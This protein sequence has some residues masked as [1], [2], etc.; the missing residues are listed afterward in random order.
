MTSI[1]VLQHIVTKETDRLEAH[2]RPSRNSGWEYRIFDKQTQKSVPERDWTEANDEA[3]ARAN[4][5][6]NLKAA[7]SEL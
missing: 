4:A 6:F 3:T 5:H 1:L 7:D 2:V